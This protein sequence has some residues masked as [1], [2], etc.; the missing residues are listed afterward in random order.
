MCLVNRALAKL[1]HVPNTHQNHRDPLLKEMPRQEDSRLLHTEADVI[2][3]SHLYLLNSVNSAVERLLPAGYTL[4]CRG[5]VTLNKARN[6]V[7]WTLFYN[8]MEVDIAIM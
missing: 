3:T 2:R 6:D 4:K 7:T 1:P 8:R 5:E